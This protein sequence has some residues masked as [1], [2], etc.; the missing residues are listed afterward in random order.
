MNR[1]VPPKELRS[2]AA[3]LETSMLEELAKEDMIG[4]EFSSDFQR[5]MEA[6]LVRARHQEQIRKT[7]RTVAASFAVVVLLAFSWL[8]SNAEARTS[9]Q[10]S[11]RE[12]W[13]KSISFLSGFGLDIPEEWAKMDPEFDIPVDPQEQD[14]GFLIPWGEKDDTPA[15]VP[16]PDD[17]EADNDITIVPIE[18][19]DDGAKVVYS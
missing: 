8:A 2:A 10:R 9:V 15:I 18:P 11:I 6:V 3:T 17:T 1:V 14:P 4:H 19:Y 16:I 12:T 13:Q 7:I 5:K